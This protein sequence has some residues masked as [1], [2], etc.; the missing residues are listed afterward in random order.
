M[1]LLIVSASIRN[2]LRPDRLFDGDRVAAW[3]A[4]PVAAAA[5]AAGD[6]GAA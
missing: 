3:P 4:S 6:A 2:A 5:A 1:R